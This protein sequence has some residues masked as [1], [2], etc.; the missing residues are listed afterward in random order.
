MAAIIGV[1]AIF[2]HT[3][4][5]EA[6]WTTAPTQ[7]AWDQEIWAAAALLHVYSKVVLKA[8]SLEAARDEVSRNNFK[9]I[10]LNP[11]WLSKL[12]I[13]DIVQYPPQGKGKKKKHYI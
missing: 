8:L 3:H 2:R 4:L 9:S 1:Y 10:L 7:N 6:F 5:S 13:A 11:G 12:D